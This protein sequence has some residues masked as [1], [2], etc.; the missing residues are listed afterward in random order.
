MEAMNE[1]WFVMS[2]YVGMVGVVYGTAF[3][4]LW[5]KNGPRKK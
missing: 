2:I 4:L 5:V 3:A 1:T